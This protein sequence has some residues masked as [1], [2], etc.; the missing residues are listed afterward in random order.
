MESA[1][2]AAPIALGRRPRVAVLATRAASGEKGG[3]ERFYVGLCDAMTAAGA[4]AHIRWEVS[5]E[6]NFEEIKKSYLRCYDCNLTDYDGVISTKAPSYLV[7]HRNHICY[8]LHTMRVFYDMF[9][10]E[11]TNPNDTLA[12]QRAL[13]HTLDTAALQT[14]RTRKIFTIGHEVRQRLESFNGLAAEVLYPATTLSGFRCGA[15]RDFFLPGRLHRWKR[16]GLA[17]E[18]MQRLDSSAQLLI[19]G[20][21]EDEARLKALA[22]ADPRIRF[23]GRVSDDELLGLYADALAVV[24][25]PSREDFGYIA[26]EAFL[27]GKPVITCTDSG[28]PARLVRNDV[29]GFVVSPDPTSLAC[30][31]K[32]MIDDSER[33][34]A[35][36][37]QGRE[38]VQAIDW[39]KVG[40]ALMTALGFARQE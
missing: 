30:A 24:F 13:V 39:A 40:D 15:S 32:K 16:V 18:A 33:A 14:P 25:T 35:M 7:R 27:S 3:A 21:G 26:V 19:C 17:I 5:D 2:T 28:E 37:R 6:S 34:Q 38:D 29:S 11:F 8:L 22:A 12:Q 10:V 31:M 1:M 9:D 4:D 23:L 20:T 36:G